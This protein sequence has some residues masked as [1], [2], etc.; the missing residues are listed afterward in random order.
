VHREGFGGDR[1]FATNIYVG[2]TI[3]KGRAT[4]DLGLRF[5]RQTGKALA[6]DTQSNPAFPNLVPGISFAGYDAPFKWNNFSP[7]AGITYALDESRKTIV[8]AAFSR[9]ASQLA[10][11]IVGYTNPSSGAGWA[12][13][14]WSDANGDHLAQ[15]NEVLTN[16]FITAGGGFNPAN[17]TSVT[18]AD[19]VDPDLKAPVTTSIVTGVDREVLPS[20]TISQPRRSQGRC[21]EWALTAFP[22]SGPIQ[23]R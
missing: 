22:R 10:T 2:D 19:L 12:E 17:P 4:V 7:R 18:S 11:G 15:A 16:Q 1:V 6:S 21:R 20:T 9:Y 14:R 13:Y 3:Q 23:W 5:D 8:R